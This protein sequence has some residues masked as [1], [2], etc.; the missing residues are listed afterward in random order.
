MAVAQQMRR[1]L[2]DVTDA[3]AVKQVGSS[4]DG[5]TVKLELFNYQTEVTLVSAETVTIQ[6]PAVAEAAGLTFT[7]R[8]TT[9]GGGVTISDSDDSVEWGGDYTTDA[10]GEYITFTSTGSQW[11]VV[12]TDI[13]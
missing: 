13:S 8:A 3:N 12:V 11:V 1:R 4:D 9:D 2:E 7:I 10:D 6:L 5:T